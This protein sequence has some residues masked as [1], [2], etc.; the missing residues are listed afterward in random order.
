[1]NAFSLAS[2]A[3]LIGAELHGDPA[4]QVS[5]VAPL[6]EAGPAELTFLTS[7]KFRKQLPDTRAGVVILKADD[8]EACPVNAL[9]SENPYLAY[10]LVVQ[11]MS[12]SEPNAPGVHPSAVVDASARIDA[13]ARVEANCTIGANVEI[14]AGAL[15]GPNCVIAEG[16]RLGENTRLVAS[17]TLGGQTELGARCLVQPGAVIGGDGFGFANDQGRWV[18]VPQLG[19]VI[20]GNDVEIGACTTVDRGAIKDTVI[21]DGVKLD[22]QIQIAHNVEVGEHTA[23]AAGVGVSGSTRIGAYCTL[24]G[25]AGLAGHLELADRV[26]ISGMTAVAGS[27]REPGVYTSTVPAMSHDRWRKNFVRLKQLDDMAR[28]LK[29]LEKALAASKPGDNND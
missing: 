14:A 21:K 2:L 18:K 15:I 11:A 5:G 27:I 6:D 19:R 10:A 13:A 23:M 29:A 22:N 4:H 26:H 25:A 20:I 7:A 9:V 24:A 3:E 16:C 28:R 17:V 12:A 1:M 8:L